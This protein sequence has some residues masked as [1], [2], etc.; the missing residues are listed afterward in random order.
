MDA[1]H[2]AAHGSMRTNQG[3]HNR[4]LGSSRH[5]N[6]NSLFKGGGRESIPYII[7]ILRRG[8]VDNQ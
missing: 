5:A 2:I 6:E 7:W 1:N 4:A 3:D 8:D